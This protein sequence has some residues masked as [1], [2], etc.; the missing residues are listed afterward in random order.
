MVAYRL[1]ELE[2]RM[3]EW[4]TDV[5]SIGKTVTEINTKMDSIAT[6][7]YVLTLFG[8]TGGLAVLAFI[9]HLLIRILVGSPPP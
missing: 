6:K 5:K 3:G 4:E 9:G 7:A 2:R 1:D 8:I